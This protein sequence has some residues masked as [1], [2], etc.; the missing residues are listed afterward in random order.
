MHFTTIATLFT[1]LA[2]A[3]SLPTTPSPNDYLFIEDP[4][5]HP[6]LYITPTPE[7]S[8]PKVVQNMPM[9]VPIGS[10]QGLAGLGSLLGSHS[11]GSP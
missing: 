9:V 5:V 7:E 1:V 3:A 2:I 11:R 10:H 4:E 8:K 6:Q